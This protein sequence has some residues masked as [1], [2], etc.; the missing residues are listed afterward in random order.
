MEL[1]V[2]REVD[3]LV[4]PVI[5]RFMRMG[6]KVG[7]LTDVVILVRRVRVAVAL[8]LDGAIFADS[9]GNHKGNTEMLMVLK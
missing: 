7:L 5:P 1:F 3:F 2:S 6:A 9:D 4:V 8:M